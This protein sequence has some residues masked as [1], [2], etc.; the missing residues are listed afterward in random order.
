Q[1]TELPRAEQIGNLA[2]KRGAQALPM[3]PAAQQFQRLSTVP[4]RVRPRSIEDGTMPG[5]VSAG[6]LERISNDDPYGA[7]LLLDGIDAGLSDS[8]RAEWRQRVA[9]SFYIENQDAQAY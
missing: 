4:R 6:I 2:L 5:N 1:G 7:K 9:W 3:L 8:A